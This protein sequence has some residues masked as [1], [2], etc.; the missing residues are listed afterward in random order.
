MRNSFWK[1]ITND[2]YWFFTNFYVNMIIQF[3]H[4]L[5]ADVLSSAKLQAM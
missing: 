1:I 4:E 3:T 2:I 5:E